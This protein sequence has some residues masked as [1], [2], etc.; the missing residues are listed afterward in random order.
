[1]P[2]KYTTDTILK[3]YNNYF[4]PKTQQDN[5]SNN[6]NNWLDQITF[7]TFS[8]VYYDIAVSNDETKMRRTY[9]QLTKLNTSRSAIFSK[10]KNG[11]S[12]PKQP[13]QT[14]PHPKLET[15]FDI[16][17]LEKLR[18][19]I[20]SSSK[21]YLTLIRKSIIES[22]NGIVNQYEFR[23]IIKSLGLGLTSVE[24]ETIINT[25]GKTRDNKI[26]LNDFYKFVANDDKNLIKA[27]LNIKSTLADIKQLLYKYY[28]NPKLAFEF[29]DNN[30]T[31]QMDF[32]TFKCIIGEMYKR[33][34]KQTPN[35]ALLKETFDVIDLRKDGYIDMNEWTNSFGRNKGKLD[36][37]TNKKQ[38]SSLRQWETSDGVIAIYKAI[39][40]N[41]KVIWDKVKGVSFGKGNG[42]VVQEDNLIKVL[43]E[44]FPD[45][46]LTN[47][48]WKMIV[49]IADKDPSSDLIHFEQFIK[50]VEHCAT[51]A[52]SQPRI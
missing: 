39:A 25:S 29:S 49:E 50:I 18:K 20:H 51:K 9:T 41:K 1:M 38:V 24:I 47:T 32:D 48:Q 14:L 4:V 28:S 8:F 21:D 26:N 10:T 31:N 37:I 44:V 45:L 7:S 27:Q 46:K 33:E 40:H 42:A 22:G 34:C 36:L 16:D 43:K 11:F 3:Y 6:N 23:N 12:L 52:K 2:K 17:P 19:L 5:N 30:K 15:P 35:F 13:F